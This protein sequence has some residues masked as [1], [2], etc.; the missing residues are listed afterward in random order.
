MTGAAYLVIEF[1]VNHAAAIKDQS[2]QVELN[3]ATANDAAGEWE[4]A[5]KLE[6]LS[7]GLKD[8][9]NTV[10]IPLEGAPFDITKWQWLRVFNT[11]D[12]TLDED[13]IFAIKEMYLEKAGSEKGTVVSDCAPTRKGWGSKALTRFWIADENDPKDYDRTYVG[14]T[15]TGTLDVNGMGLYFNRLKAYPKEKDADNRTIDVSFA[16]F[17]VF[18]LYVSDASKIKD[19]QVALEINSNPAGA[20]DH[21]ERQWNT[22]YD[23]LADYKLHDGW[24][25]IRV[26]LDNGQLTD[27][28]GAQKFD[29]TQVCWFR[30]F[31]LEAV[32]AGEGLDLG[33]DNIYF[34]DGYTSL[35]DGFEY[36]SYTAVGHKNNEYV[37]SSDGAGKHPDDFFFADKT[38]EVIMKFDIQNAA[39]A[40]TAYIITKTGSQLAFSVSMDGTNWTEVYNA[41]ANNTVV[42]TRYFDLDEYVDFNKS[43]TVYVKYADSVPD[44]GNGGRMYDCTLNVAY[45]VIDESAVDPHYTVMHACDSDAGLPGWSFDSEIEGATG[46]GCVSKVFKGNVAAPA[47]FTFRLVCADTRVQSYDTTNFAAICFDLYVSNADVLKDTTF[48]IEFTSQGQ[49]DHEEDATDAKLSSFV[50]EG[51]TWKNGWN[52][53][54]I[55]FEKLTGKTDGGLNRAKM[56]YIR[57]FNSSAIAAGEEGITV[58]WD[59]IRLWDGSDGTIYTEVAGTKVTDTIT[60]FVFTDYLDVKDL[61]I[62]GEG[63]DKIEVS[64]DGKEYVEV[65]K[66]DGKYSL[67]NL[68]DSITPNFVITYVK[69]AANAELKGHI[70]HKEI[71]SNADKDMYEYTNTTHSILLVACDNAFS[72]SSVIKSEP[73]PAAGTTSV[74]VVYANS[75]GHQT[76]NLA[77]DDIDCTGMD[78]FEFDVYFSD[79]QVMKLLS[80][81]TEGQI[82]LCSGGSCDQEETMWDFKNIVA[83]IVGTPK[84]GEWNHVVLPLSTG[85]QGQLVLDHVNYCR[86]YFHAHGAF[87]EGATE[88]DEG[89]FC[90]DN[91]RMTDYEAM[92]IID[93]MPYVATAND[94][95]AALRTLLGVESGT[96]IPDDAIT[97][98]NI[99]DVKAAYEAAVEAKDAIPTIASGEF[100]DGSFIR[101]VKSAIEKFEK[102]P[103]TPDE[104]DTKKQE[105]ESKGNSTGDETGKS[106]ESS[107]GGEKETEAPKRNGCG[108]VVIGGAV[109]VLAV[110]TAAGAM[111]VKKKD[112]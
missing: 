9:W 64:F 70:C 96:T 106:S 86:M 63:G 38:A 40:D 17:L 4:R 10:K 33:L 84:A 58:A 105:S 74:K 39:S 76:P 80:E 81:I 60:K 1:Y 91:L 78:T 104:S 22:T 6:D 98:A 35:E 12:L 8:G 36:E 89:F 101:K 65:A 28:D 99:A 11:G 73:A 43:G 92:G 32:D 94:K 97:E 55:P 77:F 14:N 88:D 5:L 16:K 41:G 19:K 49:P 112:N 62:D 29:A 66:A 59:N 45:E 79:E 95:V 24:N 23:G 21:Y 44:D 53:L 109:V 51:T 26:G 107:Q 27:Q 90:I 71:I 67:A 83:G 102:G 68:I 72:G 75:E 85:N 48:N 108:S 37:V 52:K 34:W 100:K 50:A 25:R 56:N 87:Y 42:Q 46:K 7:G 69:A 2:I 54:V 30:L 110:V 93:A 111:I 20:P 47:G 13:L 103:D 18:D 82:E 31:N 61:Y 3:A 15:F 57:I